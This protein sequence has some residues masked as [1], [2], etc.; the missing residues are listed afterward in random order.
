MDNPT[1]IKKLLLLA[2]IVFFG[3]TAQ[4]WAAPIHYEGTLSTSDG[5]LVVG[6]SWTSATLNWEVD[7]SYTSELW[8]YS[9]DFTVGTATTGGGNSKNAKCEDPEITRVI[10][11]T[12]GDPDKLKYGDIETGTTPGWTLGTYKKSGNPGWKGGQFYGIKWVE[13]SSNNIDV[14]DYHWT[15]TIVTDHSPMWGDFYAKGEDDSYARNSGMG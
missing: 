2:L 8:T 15:W 13:T 7:Y 4:S 5:T 1:Q 12:S 11:Q 10:I 3:L 6:K 14:T 9:Y